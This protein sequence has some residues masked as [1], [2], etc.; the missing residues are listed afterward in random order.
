MAVSGDNT[1]AVPDCQ[2]MAFLN[3]LISSETHKKKFCWAPTL[4]PYEL[5][6]KVSN[7][8]SLGNTFQR[9]M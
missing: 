5:P 7:S 4:F 6:G 9:K 1:W 3:Y 2:I 8:S